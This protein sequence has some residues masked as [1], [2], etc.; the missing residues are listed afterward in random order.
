MQTERPSPPAPATHTPRPGPGPAVYWRHPRWFE[1]GFWIVFTVLNAI[2]NSQVAQMDV[3]R[4]GLGV[5]A[6][7]PVAW[8]WTSGLAILA[9]VPAVAWYSRRWPLHWDTLARSLPMHVVGSVLFS[10]AHVVA[11]VA[12]REGVYALRGLDYDFGPWGRSLVYEYLKDA[13]GYLMI[14]AIVE[15]YRFIVRRLRG[16]A[17]LLAPPDEGEPVEPVDRPERFLVRKLGREFLVAAADIEWLQASGNYVNLRVRGHD[18]PLR[19]TIAG[20]EARLD[21]AR[22]VRVH[23]SWIVNLARVGSIEPLET[24]DARVHMADGA[25]VPCSRTFRDAL[26]AQVGRG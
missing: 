19:S 12:M 8:E 14:V 13:R 23:R 1:A 18:Y 11:M 24:G 10:L 17:M 16:E 7:K 4:A 15:G 26:R 22:F 3:A 20:I 5:D 9:L 21:P 25:V 2:A 6:W